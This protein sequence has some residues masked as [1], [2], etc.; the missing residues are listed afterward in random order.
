M[1]AFA[2]DWFTTDDHAEKDRLPLC[3][4]RLSGLLG[5]LDLEPSPD[6][7]F[8]ART[9]SC[10]LP[11]T[12]LTTC[13][14]TCAR[15]CRRPDQCLT[16]GADDL[17]LLRPVGGLFTVEQNGRRTIVE[18]RDAVLISTQ[19]PWTLDLSELERLDCL[20]VPRAIAG[21][22]PGALL[23][24]LPRLIKRD[25]PA[26]QLL[27]HYGGALLQGILPLGT[28]ELRHIASCHVQDLL[29]ML[30][31]TDEQDNRTEPSRLGLAKRDIE[32]NLAD[33]GLSIESIA[34]RQGVTP[35]TLQKLFEA[36]G[37]TFSE[38]VLDKRLSFAK[39]AL[40]RDRVRKI[41]DIAY[42][43]GFGDLSYFNRAFRRRYGMTP[44]QA[45]SEHIN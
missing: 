44:R 36:D 18:E 41:S 38:Y 5:A 19:V 3:R 43:A 30:L 4:Q 6:V 45:R 32:N 29:R 12:C 16:D 21:T 17:V 34:R 1:T 25:D 27:A 9:V 40:H 23:P 42:E 22:A 35:R 24:N 10:Q 28:P 13:F 2:P 26:F 20:R 11:G 8:R 39:I 14:L 7:P 33:R 15:A 37:T 31:Q